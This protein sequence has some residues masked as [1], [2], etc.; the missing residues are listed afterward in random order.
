L[1]IGQLKTDDNLWKL[2]YNNGV[3]QTRLRRQVEWI[4]AGRTQS[5][6]GG[7]CASPGTPWL[8]A[9]FENGIG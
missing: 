5:W 9:C 7:D 8:C 4:Q 3:H 1:K 6:G 2:I